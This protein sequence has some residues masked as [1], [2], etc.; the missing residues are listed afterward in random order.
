M[1]SLLQNNPGLELDIAIFIILVFIVFFYYFLQRISKNKLDMFKTKR[2]IKINSR[3]Y[4]QKL[5]L[6]G[7]QTYDTDGYWWGKEGKRY[8][9][10]FDSAEQAKAALP[11]YEVV[12]KF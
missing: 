6:F 3:Y 2:I 1:A 7:W 11:T 10:G 8:W 12:E 9:S 5:T 4:L